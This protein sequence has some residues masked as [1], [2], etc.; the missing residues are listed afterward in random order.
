MAIDQVRTY[1]RELGYE[2][3]II[4]FDVSSATVDLAAE[5]LKTEGKRI[6]KTLAFRYFDQTLLIVTAGDAKID[7]SKFKSKFNLKAR[8]LDYQETEEKVGHAIE[9]MC[10]FAVN[11]N[12]VVVLDESLKRFETVYPACGSASSAIE[13]NL[14]ELEK[15]SKSTQWVDV[16]KEW[17]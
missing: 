14:N 7:N 10:P 13:L 15:L 5:A 6:A 1:F 3:R 12:C 4:E 9:K 2:H 17:A 11:E 8:M 16:C